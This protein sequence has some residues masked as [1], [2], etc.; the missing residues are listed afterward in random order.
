M[1]Q[2][3]RRK[4]PGIV[5][6]L[7][8]NV[9]HAS[10]VHEKWRTRRESKLA[11]STGVNESTRAIAYALACTIVREPAQPVERLGAQLADPRLRD[12]QFGGDLPQRPLLEIRAGN[13]Q[14]LT[15]R[16]GVERGLD[17]AAPLGGLE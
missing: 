6:D 5:D 8:E 1:V 15:G 9:P 16:Q 11:G 14:P 17:R 7:G 4:E 3:G 12:T 2:V 13:H 10:P